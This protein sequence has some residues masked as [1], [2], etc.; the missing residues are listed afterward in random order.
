MTGWPL[1]REGQLLSLTVPKT[2]MIVSIDIGDF[3]SVH[4]ANKKA[5]AQRL[6]LW[7]R[8][9]VY[10]EKIPW[11][12]PLFTGFKVQG[13]EIELSFRHT[14]GGMIAK[15][16]DLRGFVIAGADKQ[17]HAARARIAKDKVLVSSPDVK[18]P[19]AVRYSWADNPD[20]N[21][22]NAAGLPASPFRTD[23]D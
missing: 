20:G 14:D 13:S 10:G 8:A 9:E 16:G 19:V 3:D 11:S 23:T 7:A 18:T 1:I 21:L 6:A 22:C 15:N 2:G 17:W 5:F 4:P 12:G